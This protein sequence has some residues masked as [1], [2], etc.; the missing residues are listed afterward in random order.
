MQRVQMLPALRIGADLQADD[1]AFLASCPVAIGVAGAALAFLQLFHALQQPEGIPANH[2]V[3]RLKLC[4][5]R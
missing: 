2:V 5:L 1:H 4:Q 3:G